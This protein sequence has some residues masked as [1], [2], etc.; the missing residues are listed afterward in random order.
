M[1]AVMQLGDPGAAKEDATQVLDAL[2]AGGVPLSPKI[3]RELIQKALYRCE[4][5][6]A[7][8]PPAGVLCSR[9]QQLPGSQYNPS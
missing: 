5:V 6:V 9:Q 3:V 7:V 2:Q 4:P 8:W 1:I